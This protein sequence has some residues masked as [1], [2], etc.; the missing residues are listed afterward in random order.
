MS[1]ALVSVSA[2]V[3]QPQNKGDKLCTQLISQRLAECVEL[4]KLIHEK[5]DESLNE[6]Y[7]EEERR[8]LRR[9]CYNLAKKRKEARTEAETLLEIIKG[10]ARNESLASG[11]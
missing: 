2:P 1:R 9:Q 8:N 3:L 11:Q 6:Q 5:Y 4:G 7:S 10:A